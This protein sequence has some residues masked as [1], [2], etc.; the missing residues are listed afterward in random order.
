M[1][2]PDAAVGPVRGATVSVGLESL[3]PLK[4]HHHVPPSW[5]TVMRALAA[6]SRGLAVAEGIGIGLCLLAVVGLATWQFVE[7]NLVM[8]HLPFFPVPPW[9]NRLIRP[10]PFLP[11]SPPAPS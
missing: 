8:R 7:R 6:L 5:P 2:P 10:P 9:P 4:P 1:L 3:P 11:P